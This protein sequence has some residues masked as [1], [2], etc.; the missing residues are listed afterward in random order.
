LLLLSRRGRVLGIA[1]HRQRHN[2]LA[3]KPAGNLEAAHGNVASRKDPSRRA[4]SRR[5]PDMPQKARRA[6]WTGQ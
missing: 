1:A 4:Q 2:A 5:M 3:R 6:P